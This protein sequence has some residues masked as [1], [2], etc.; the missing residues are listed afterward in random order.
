MKIECRCYFDETTMIWLDL[1]G[2]SVQ[3]TKDI[4]AVLAVN[5][6]DEVDDHYLNTRAPIRPIGYKTT[7]F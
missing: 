1:E 6:N 4:L 2:N 7:I 5:Y 3:Y